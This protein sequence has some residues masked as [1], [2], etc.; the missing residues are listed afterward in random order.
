MFTNIKRT[1]HPKKKHI[2]FFNPLSK[3]IFFL[4]LLN[5]KTIKLRHIFLV[6]DPF[7]V[8]FNNQII[9][10]LHSCNIRLHS[11]NVRYRV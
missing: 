5:V 8:V 4:K 6:D 2:L 7:L 1:I 3:I 9:M 10:V 11:I